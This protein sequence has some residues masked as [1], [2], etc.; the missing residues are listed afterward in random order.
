MLPEADRIRLTHVLGYAT[1]A[2][3]FTSGRT[4]ADL[5][6]DPMLAHSLI[7]CLEVAGE[8]AA[9]LSTATREALPQIPWRAMVSMRNRLIHAY[10]RVNLDIVWQAATVEFPPIIAELERILAEA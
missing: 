9:Q 2:V 8:A 7:R 5:D 3:S 10:H 4:R 1:Q 6:N